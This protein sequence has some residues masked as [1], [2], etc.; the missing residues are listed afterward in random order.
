MPDN[1]NK[2]SQFWQ[3]LKRR[4]VIHVIIVYAT[5]AFV[6]IELVNNVTEP[7][8]LP[9]WTPTMVIIILLVGFPLAIIFSWI[10]DVTPDGIERT[11]PSKE[12][13]KGEN[14]LVPNSWRIATYVSM[15]VI[16]GLV[17]YNLFGGKNRF[18]I[19]E[20]LEKSIAVLPFQNFSTDPDQEAM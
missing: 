11:K 20:S 15:V 10:F 6:I 8:K 1:P 7:L 9:E 18:N 19:D 14:T 2:L 16:L 5:A 4:R 3:E 17:A 13:K 12:L